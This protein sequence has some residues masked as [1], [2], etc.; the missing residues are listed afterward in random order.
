MKIQ[1]TIKSVYGVER[2]FPVCKA[3]KLLASLTGRPTF[4]DKQIE[5]L[6]KLGYTPEVVYEKKAV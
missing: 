4:T 3:A 2:I 6:K 1:V 5:T